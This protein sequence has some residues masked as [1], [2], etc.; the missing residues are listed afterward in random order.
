M[1]RVKYFVIKGF[2]FLPIHI[3][4]F[5]NYTAIKL[6]ILVYYLLIFPKFIVKYTVYNTYLFKYFIPVSI[7]WL[8]LYLLILYIRILSFIQLRD[9]YNLLYRYVKSI[10]K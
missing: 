6:N 5:S 4:K 1:I 2:V 7:R 8:F 10:N 3:G 9:F